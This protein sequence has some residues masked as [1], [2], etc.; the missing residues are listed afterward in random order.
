MTKKSDCREPVK[1]YQTHG[2]KKLRELKI[3][4]RIA[5]V[6]YA[7]M[8][9]AT[10]N[11]QLAIKT[12]DGSSILAEISAGSAT[13]GN[14]EPYL[15]NKHEEE[16]IPKYPIVYRY[17]ASAL[18]GSWISGYAWYESVL[19]EAEIGSYK[20]EYGGYPETKYAM[21]NPRILSDVPAC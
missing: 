10:G 9:T 3:T 4:A 6:Y 14:I 7:R 13:A 11:F 2:K 1:E 19:S 12:E 8:N 21:K 20:P 18:V 17:D 5:R 16:S 15:K